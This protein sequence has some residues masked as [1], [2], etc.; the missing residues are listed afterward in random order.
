MA[1]YTMLLE[2]RYS[3]DDQGYFFLCFANMRKGGASTKITNIMKNC[4]G[5]VEGVTYKM[6]ASGLRVG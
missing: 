1:C 6:T 2:G 4:V 5:K 3:S